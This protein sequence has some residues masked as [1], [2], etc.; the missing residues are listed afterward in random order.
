M[1]IDSELNGLMNQVLLHR[2]M[3]QHNPPGFLGDKPDAWVKSFP[4]ALIG[5]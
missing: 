4:E 1:C 2:P 5:S 3:I